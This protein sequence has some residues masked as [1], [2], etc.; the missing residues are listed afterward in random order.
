MI[1]DSLALPI[2]G[3]TMAGPFELPTAELPPVLGPSVGPFNY[4]FSIYPTGGATVA[5]RS[6]YVGTTMDADSAFSITNIDT[7][8]TLSSNSLIFLKG[9]VTALATTAITVT[10]GSSWTGY[11]ALIHLD[12]GPPITQDEYY[13]LIG[14]VGSLP[15]SSYLNPGFPITISGS[16]YW[17]YQR[18]RN[19]LMEQNICFNG[20]PSIYPFAFQGPVV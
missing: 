17:V 7:P 12:S 14:Y 4:P 15:S 20:T 6:G 2:P 10:V 19:D 1:P 9:D 16:Q 13:V 5:V 8:V 11:P 3:S 18:L